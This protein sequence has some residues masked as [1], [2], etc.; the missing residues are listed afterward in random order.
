MRVRHLAGAAPVEDGQAMGEVRR[1]EPRLGGQ[2]LA[3]EEDDLGGSGQ[4][5]GHATTLLREDGDHLCVAAPPGMVERC[6]SVA[7]GDRP[8][9]AGANQGADCFHMIRPAVAEDH[10]L[11]QRGP[12]KVI[13][14]VERGAGLNQRTHHFGMAEMRRGDQCGAVIG[15]GDRGRIAADS[16]GR[17]EEV[18]VVGNPAMVI[19]S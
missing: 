9:G 6:H 3:V 13:D 7:I 12:S 5:R 1:A 2:A 18:R 4:V 14:V 16:D 11:D 19:A 8:V 15:A 17:P 10:G